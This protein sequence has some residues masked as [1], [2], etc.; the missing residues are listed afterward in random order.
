[1]TKELFNKLVGHNDN[2]C[3]ITAEALSNKEDRT[4]LYGINENGNNIHVYL[5]DK[6]IYVVE[7]DLESHMKIA[8]HLH[9]SKNA[10]YIPNKLVYPFACDYEFCYI[11]RNRLNYAMTFAPFEEWAKEKYYGFVYEELCDF[12]K[13]K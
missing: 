4:L 2:E 12:F 10:D 11:L 9:P 13:E 7:Y 6:K 5:K 3:L 1:M 8:Y